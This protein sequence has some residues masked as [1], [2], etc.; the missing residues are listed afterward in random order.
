MPR[1][2]GKTRALGWLRGRLNSRCF[3]A[4]LGAFLHRLGLG[5]DLLRERTEFLALVRP[6]PRTALREL[7]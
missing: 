3:L 2:H 4:R 1:R 7:Q 6:L 5:R